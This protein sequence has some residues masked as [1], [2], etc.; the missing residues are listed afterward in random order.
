MV[1]NDVKNKAFSRAP[2]TRDVWDAA[3]IVIYTVAC[4]QVHI[5][6]TGNE[7]PHS[8]KEKWLSSGSDKI[9]YPL[10]M[11]GEALKGKLSSSFPLSFWKLFPGHLRLCYEPTRLFWGFTGAHWLWKWEEYVRLS[12]WQSG[13]GSEALVEGAGMRQASLSHSCLEG[14]NCNLEGQLPAF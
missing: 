5:F 13:L 6:V 4:Q 9:G 14:G 8:W 10:R 7:C 3:I 12:I 11:E 2:I 1:W